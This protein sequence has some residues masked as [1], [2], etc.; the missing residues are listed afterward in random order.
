MAE[1]LCIL[2]HLDKLVLQF[3]FVSGDMVSIK[4]IYT[5]RTYTK[6]TEQPATCTIDMHAR[7]QT[8]Q[9]DKDRHS[10]NYDLSQYYHHLIAQYQRAAAVTQHALITCDSLA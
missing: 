5:C 7:V 1:T 4:Q 8:P 3:H 6:D 10:V 9:L 2:F